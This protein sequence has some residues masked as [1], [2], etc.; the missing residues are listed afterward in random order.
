M[1]SVAQGT[2]CHPTAYPQLGPGHLGQLSWGHNVFSWG[3]LGLGP[4]E[5]MLVRL[6]LGQLCLLKE[7]VVALKQ[8]IQSWAC[9]ATGFMALQRVPV[10]AN[11]PKGPG[12][13]RGSPPAFP[14]L[15]ASPVAGVGGW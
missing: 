12:Q 15:A 2:Q 3:T 5:P 10:Q 14:S 1:P 11:R 13:G 8:H 7:L 9:T 6:L 4:P